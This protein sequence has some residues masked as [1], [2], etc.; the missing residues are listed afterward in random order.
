[1]P[2]LFDFNHDVF[3]YVTENASIN[4][5]ISTSYSKDSRQQSSF[6][7]AIQ[8]LEVSAGISAKLT[9]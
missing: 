4:T 8:K 7:N 9:F 1:M 5:M 3:V 6:N 2:L